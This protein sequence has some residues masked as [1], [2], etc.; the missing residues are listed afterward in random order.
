[1]YEANETAAV[2]LFSLRAMGSIAFIAVYA[3]VLRIAMRL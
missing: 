3:C 1:M 2:I